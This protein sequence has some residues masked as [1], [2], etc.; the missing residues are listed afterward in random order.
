MGDNSDKSTNREAGNGGTSNLKVLLLLTPLLTVTLMAIVGLDVLRNDS[1]IS[2][3]ITI[4]QVLIGTTALMLANDIANVIPRDMLESIPEDVRDTTSYII[5]WA[6]TIPFVLSAPFWILGDLRFAAA[7]LPQYADFFNTLASAYK[8]LIIV[9]I[10]LV[11]LL[12][13][14]GRGGGTGTETDSTVKWYA[15]YKFWD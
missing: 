6:G 1:Y 8:V 4:F 5:L 7:A 10:G 2:G 14:S 9:L 11:W 3:V 13:D 12:K 15:F